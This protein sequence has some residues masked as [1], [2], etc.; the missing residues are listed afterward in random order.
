MVSSEQATRGTTSRSPEQNLNN[1]AVQYHGVGH[2]ITG[3]PRDRRRRLKLRHS[4]KNRASTREIG[5]TR[6]EKDR[7]R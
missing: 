2:A 7:V 5:P 1:R 4:Q 3:A 6:A